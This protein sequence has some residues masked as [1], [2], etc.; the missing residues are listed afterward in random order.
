[1]DV[2]CSYSVDTGSVSFLMTETELNDRLYNIVNSCHGNNI[3]VWYT[4]A[5]GFV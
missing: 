2:S 5:S 1:M 4:F 3:Q